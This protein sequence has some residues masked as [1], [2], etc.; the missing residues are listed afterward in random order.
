MLLIPAVLTLVSASVKNDGLGPGRNVWKVGN[1]ADYGLNA[2]L[3]ERA[4]ALIKERVS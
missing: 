3:L 2:T 4:A 1:P